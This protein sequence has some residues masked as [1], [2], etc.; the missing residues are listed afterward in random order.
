M[1]RMAAGK[2]NGV[3]FHMSPFLR[4]RPVRLC[5]ALIS[6]A[7]YL[8]YLKQVKQGCLPLHGEYL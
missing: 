2:Q 5:S 7:L 3:C 1:P 6:E 8:P 4:L